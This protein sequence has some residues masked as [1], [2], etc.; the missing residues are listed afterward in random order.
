MTLKTF[1]RNSYPYRILSLLRDY[2]AWAGR[3]FYA[4]SPHFIK[5][6]CL[7]RNSF[8]NATWV[9]TGTY[10]GQTT[11][12]LSKHGSK[13]YSIEPEPA[14]FARA[15][16][17]FANFRNVEILNG[18][19]EQVFPNLLPKINGDVNFWLDAHYSEGITFKGTQ[20]TP[21]VDELNYIGDN[22]GHFSEVCVLIDDIRCFNPQKS[23]Y[24]TY[25]PAD[26]LVD[27]ARKNSL[28]WYVEHDIFV[29]KTNR[30]NSNLQH[31]S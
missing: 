31:C 17:Y 29:A 26:V 8:P 24:S 18:T 16:E 22:L 10:L 13:V 5:Q 12:V 9:E 25:P 19:S 2:K 6:A 11:E 3:R 27:W 7:I 1:I 15:K 4:P 30:L 28:S 20:D 21:I 23:E 14:L